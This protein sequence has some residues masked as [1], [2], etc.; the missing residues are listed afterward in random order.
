MT[1][2][3]RTLYTIVLLL[4]AFLSAERAN[5]QPACDPEVEIKRFLKAEYGRG[6]QT[7][8]AFDHQTQQWSA[9]IWKDNR[10]S[11]LG[12]PDFES[13]F[14]NKPR[15]FLPKGEQP[16]VLVVNTDPMLF[17]TSFTG[18]TEAPIEDLASLQKLA[19]LLGG[20]VSAKV[21]LLPPEF[22]PQ[23]A[24]RALSATV[25]IAMAP[26]KR[27]QADANLWDPVKSLLEQ[28]KKPTEDIGTALDTLKKPGGELEAQLQTINAANAEI[29]NYLQMIE[30]RSAGGIEPRSRFDQLAS[31]PSQLAEV[32]KRFDEIAA[33][34]AALQNVKPVCPVA[35]AALRD[36]ARLFR[37]PL[38]DNK[39]PEKRAAVDAFLKALESI[40]ADPG[41]AALNAPV[42]K[43]KESLKELHRDGAGPPSAQGATPEQD[44]ALR[45]LVEGLNAYLSQVDQ[46]S[47]ALKATNELMAKRGDTSKVAGAVDVTLQRRK[48]HLLSNDP[49][50]LVTGV[51]E[52]TRPGAGDTDLRWSQ[53]RSEGFKIVVDSPYKDSVTLNNHATDLTPGYELRRAGRWDFD[54]DVA[55]VY[56]ELAD[57]EFSAVDDDKSA[58][59]PPIIEQTGEK[60]RA[61]ELGMFVSFQRR[62]TGRDQFSFGPQ[63][64]A[65]LSTDHPAFFAGFGIGI[66]RY[67]KLGFGWTWQRVKEL[68]DNKIGDPVAKTEDIKTR[69]AFDDNYYISLSI[70]L[71]E[72]PFF[73][74]P[75]K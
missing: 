49:C 62:L 42:L 64:G 28:L 65:G 72:L 56:T 47:T 13:A 53:V 43:I 27:V 33:A 24:G 32:E 55:T 4:L 12:S 2:L 3:R 50:S 67:A 22:D 41:C 61:G 63:I 71:D 66:S 21:A 10:L 11:S 36:A 58:T 38:P 59:T 52:V 57:P 37:T 39:L 45:P 70:T 20:F 7:V 23:A 29:K 16:I 69:D 40:D 1:P 34:A 54:V 18:A 75:D 30:S 14:T 5:A 46:R 31:S 8:L 48:D 51:L 6:P 73:K 60:T 15:L 26:E 35:L 68:K 17:A 25:R 9:Y 19:G 74:A 44:R